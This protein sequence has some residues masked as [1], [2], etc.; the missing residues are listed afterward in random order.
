M[1]RERGILIFKILT[2]RQG[3]SDLV[4]LSSTNTLHRFSSSWIIGSEANMDTFFP[5][6]WKLDMFSFFMLGFSVHQIL[7]MSSFEI[8]RRAYPVFL[9]YLGATAA[10]FVALVLL[11]S[12]DPVVRLVRFSLAISLFNAGLFGRML[13]YRAF[14]HKLHKFP[15]PWPAKLSNF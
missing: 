2:S 3:R 11:G 1:C 13:L 9:A 8:D 6:N 10:L 5:S 7:Q 4:K 15:G 14:F 12:S